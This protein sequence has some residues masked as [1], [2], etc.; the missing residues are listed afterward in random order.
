MARGRRPLAE[1]TLSVHRVLDNYATHKMPAVRRWLL[2]RP[3]CHLHSTPTSS[4]WLNLVESF[5]SILT[6]RRLK[7]GVHRGTVALERGIRSLLDNHNDEPRPFAWTKTTDEI[8]NN[9]E[10]YCTGITG[11]SAE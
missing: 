4:S 11:E 8:L 9:L 5:S 1:L 7:R 6:G 2:R 10:R 3:R